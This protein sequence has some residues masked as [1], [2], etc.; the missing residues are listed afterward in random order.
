M[1][2]QLHTVLESS[3]DT[4][5]SDAEAHAVSTISCY[6]PRAYTRGR[7]TQTGQVENYS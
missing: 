1:T 7:V 5:W 2:T 4:H 6:L 3:L